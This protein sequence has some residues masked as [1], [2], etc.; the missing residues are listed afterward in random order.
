MSVQ[1]SRTSR[2]TSAAICDWKLKTKKIDETAFVK[3]ARGQYIFTL[4]NL[5]YY[6]GV[7][8]ISH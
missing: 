3:P 7:F 8:K 2:V 1:L 5:N 6:F 4:D